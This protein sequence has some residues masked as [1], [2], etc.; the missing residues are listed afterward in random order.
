MK[1]LLQVVFTVQ[2]IRNLT[3][4]L[5]HKNSI[6]GIED[7]QNCSRIQ[8]MSISLSA[9]LFK[10]ISKAPISLFL[11]FFFGSWKSGYPAIRYAL[12]NLFLS[13]NNEKPDSME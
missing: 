5:V 12:N 13:H 9:K 10:G 6:E 4:F 11:S 8:R 3:Q 1:I 7:S 2:F